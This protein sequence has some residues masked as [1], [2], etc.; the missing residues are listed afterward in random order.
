MSRG[1]FIH[2]DIDKTPALN[3]EKSMTFLSHYV[4]GIARDGS[5]TMVVAISKLWAWYFGLENA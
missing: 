1:K 5:F 3:I 4:I 2:E